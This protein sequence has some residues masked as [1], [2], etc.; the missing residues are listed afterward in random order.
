MRKLLK[1]LWAITNRQKIPRLPRI[2]AA[3]Y[4]HVT[5]D[6]ARI[7][8]RYGIRSPSGMRAAMKKYR[9]ATADELAAVLE[10]FRPRRNLQARIRRGLLRLSGGTLRNPHTDEIKR[11]NPRSPVEREI[12]ERIRR[13]SR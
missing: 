6:E 9:V 10:H 8:T 1:Y 4:D 5:A 3:E 12:Q 2:A 7:M 11:V 13:L